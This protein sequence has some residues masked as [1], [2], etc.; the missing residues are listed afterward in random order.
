MG[1]IRRAEA[2]MTPQQFIIMSWF[3]TAASRC[4]FDRSPKGEAEKSF[5]KLIEP[6]AARSLHAAASC[7]GRDDIMGNPFGH[8]YVSMMCELIVRDLS[9]FS[10]VATVHWTAC[11]L[12]NDLTSDEISATGS[13][14]RFAHALRLVEMTTERRSNAF[15]CC[16]LQGESEPKETTRTLICTQT[17]TAT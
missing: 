3:Q 11:S 5:P 7:L 6:V 17:Y 12:S 8:R 16:G 1:V 10:M 4:H 9:A 2:R 14:Q 15:G 13:R